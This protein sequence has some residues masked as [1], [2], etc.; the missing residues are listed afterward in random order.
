MKELSL[1]SGAGGG[2]LG[3][4]LLGWA[5]CGYVEYDDY[6]QRVIRARIDDGILDDAPIFGD[7]RAFI[8]EGYADAYKGLV[9]VVTGG[10]PCQP[11]SV[12]G[13]GAG[14]DDPR[15]MWPQTLDVLCRVR[16]RYALLE[17]VPGLLAHGY[18]RRIFGD[19]AESGFD[20]RWRVLS[21]A[22][23]GAPHKRD[24]LWVCAINRDTNGNNDSAESRISQIN[25][26]AGGICEAIPDT[27]RTVWRGGI[28]GGSDKQ[29]R[30]RA[31]PK[32]ASLQPEDGETYADDAESI[33]GAVADTEGGPWER[34]EAKANTSASGRE[35]GHGSVCSGQSVADTPEQRN[36]GEREHANGSEHKESKREP[37]GSCMGQV[38]ASTCWALEPDVG[39]V[40]HG[41]AS[42]VD[43]L[44]ALGNGQV[45]VVA[46]TAWNLLNE[47]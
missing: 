46:A 31:Q 6:C 37:R 36:S 29:G 5:H 1:F 21:A 45:P 26:D 4:K 44:K 25:T 42:R 23:V 35:G 16:P 38:G 8:S 9:D 17:N 11:F 3:T 15:N 19:L 39:R 41:V 13:K 24:R 40:A 33:R 32:R 30:Q 20:A 18:A 2:L 47:T 22:E 14:E 34:E 10:F 7:I 12:A 28:G 43:R 27:Q